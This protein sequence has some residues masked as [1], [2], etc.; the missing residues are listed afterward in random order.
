MREK[1][2][3]K[4]MERCYI[5]IQSKAVKELVDLGRISFITK[6]ELAT[7]AYFRIE[8]TNTCLL[9]LAQDNGKAAYCII[10]EY[11]INHKGE[12][13][14]LVKKLAELSFH[15]SNN[16]YA[17][18]SYR[19]R[20]RTG[21]NEIVAKYGY[22]SAVVNIEQLIHTIKTGKLSTRETGLEVHHEVSV[23]DHR[24]EVSKQLDKDDHSKLSS[25]SKMNGVG[26][27]CKRELAWLILALEESKNQK[28]P[29]VDFMK[30]N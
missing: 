14:N 1:M 3:T 27:N 10:N 4:T 5:T 22:K 17:G 28:R 8:G 20:T 25:K 18:G 24:V 30:R 29:I 16:G 2:I 13:I 23:F 12:K 15:T 26:I 11:I 9:G 7:N 21:N 6:N 19:A